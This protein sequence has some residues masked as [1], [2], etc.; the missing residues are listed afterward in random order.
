[1]LSNQPVHQSPLES[2]HAA[3]FSAPYPP[4]RDI[5]YAP[6]YPPTAYQTPAHLA[7]PPY[8][9]GFALLPPPAPG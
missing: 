2:L 5:P 6:L 9:R 8:Y 3:R 7:A 4:H 1:M